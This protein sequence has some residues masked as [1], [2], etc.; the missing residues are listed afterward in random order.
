MDTGHSSSDGAGWH[1]STLRSPISTGAGPLK[2]FLGSLILGPLVTLMLATTREDAA[3]NLRQADLWTG[4]DVAKSVG[5]SL[6][7]TR[8]DL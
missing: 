4:R 6:P 3:G 8:E 2:Y 7:D 5:P 1:S